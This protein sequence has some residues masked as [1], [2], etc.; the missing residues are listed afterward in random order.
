M[1]PAYRVTQKSSFQE[2]APLKVNIFDQILLVRHESFT[3]ILPFEIKKR[4]SSH[5]V[6]F[7]LLKTLVLCTGS[8]SFLSIEMK[9]MICIQ[10]VMNAHIILMKEHSRINAANF[11]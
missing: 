3:Q 6:P 5:P 8:P 1:Y 4:K 2:A 11:A 10:R 9:H 7:P